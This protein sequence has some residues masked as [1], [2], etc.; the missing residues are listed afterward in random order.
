MRTPSFFVTAAERNP[1]LGSSRTWCG[2]KYLIST[3][4]RRYFDVISTFVD[5]ISTLISTLFR[6]YFDV[7]STFVRRIFDVISTFVRPMFDV[8]STFL[9][10]SF[11]RQ[12]RRYFDVNFDVNLNVNFDV[13]FVAWLV[14]GFSMLLIFDASLHVITVC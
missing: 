4:C 9:S 1:R 3:L 13:N 5:L 10:T 6:R 8:I 2:Y 12:F 11:R 7:M 14:V